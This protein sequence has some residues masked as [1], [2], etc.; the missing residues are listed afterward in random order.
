MNGCHLSSVL[1]VIFKHVMNDISNV[2]LAT[3]YGAT[4]GTKNEEREKAIR[5]F[6][7]SYFGEYPIGEGDGMIPCRDPD[8]HYLSPKVLEGDQKHCS[9]PKTY[10]LVD[11]VIKS[12]HGLLTD[13][14]FLDGPKVIKETCE[15]PKDN[16]FACAF[17]NY[18]E[19]FA[20]SDWNTFQNL[21]LNELMFYRLFADYYSNQIRF[22]TKYA[23][24]SNKPVSDIDQLIQEEVANMFL[25]T[26]IS[27]QAVS[28]MMRMLTQVAS[29]YPLHV[30][31]MAYLEDLINYRRTLINI[32]TPINQL[33]YTWRNAQAC[34]E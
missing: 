23:P 18:G 31:L 10:K 13:N 34:Q 32:Y 21:Y 25:E 29:T 12:A 4:E 7:T 9:H 14:I 20:E 5:E 2:K 3:L 16:L 33:F 27:Q 17:S 15:D 24:I 1:P 11:E 8:T 6:A 19:Y 22:N 28:Q 26:Q 30:A